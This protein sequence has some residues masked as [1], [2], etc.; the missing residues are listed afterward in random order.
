MVPRGYFT[1]YSVVG[2]D[3]RSG[4]HSMCWDLSASSS[5]SCLPLISSLTS[6]CL[7][8]WFLLLMGLSIP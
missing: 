6:V 3:P 5:P 8:L 4:F 2:P 1:C 7:R